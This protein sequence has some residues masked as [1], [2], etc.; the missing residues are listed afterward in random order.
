MA[1]YER[2]SVRDGHT[3]LIVSVTKYIPYDGI[4]HAG[5]QYAKDH[6]DALSGIARLVAVAPSTTANRD[7]AT[8]PG[9]PPEVVLI[10]GTGL[11]RAGRAKLLTDLASAWRGSDAQGFFR[12][13]TATPEWPWQLI[14]DADVVEF[15]WSE[16]ASL[17][18]LIRARFPEKPLVIV[19]HDVI[20]QRW[21]R[22]AGAT[23]NPLARTAYSVAA[24]R[25]ATREHADFSAAD[26]I[27]VFSEKDA[28]LVRELAPAAHPVVVAPGFRLGSTPAEGSEEEPVVLF[29]GA[30]GRP[31]NDRAVRWFLQKVWPRVIEQVGDARFVAAGSGPGR[32]LRRLVAKSH[33]AELTGFV[34]S[35]DPYYAAA[36]VFV[37][38]VL[39]GAGVKFKTVDA[40]VRGLPIV[41]TPVGAEG[42]EREDVFV[43]VTDDPVRF[44]DLV[45]AALRGAHAERAAAGG[46]WAAEVYGMDA[47]GR[48]VR[49][50]YGQLMPDRLA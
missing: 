26:R 24:R 30:L 39:T 45:V 4:P 5:G 42:I 15:Q 38:P 34:P 41:A 25:S 22:A 47:F 46:Q 33:R 16:M 48:R 50:L 10:E 3:P 7:A 11:L 29:T 32:G 14:A 43:G 19:A 36:R 31:D 40:L 44:A 8:R 1:K 2:K 20:T 9:A 21:N 37:A 35:L 27:V 28:A 12:R 13:A 6:F 49:A 23:K 18:P 17:A